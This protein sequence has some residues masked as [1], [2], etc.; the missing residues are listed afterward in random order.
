MAVERLSDMDTCRLCG[1][2]YGNP[3][4]RLSASR[5]YC[6]RCGN[7]PRNIMVVLEMH[8]RQLAEKVRQVEKASADGTRPGD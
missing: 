4:P 1:M 6:V 8:G 5:S 2:P 3:D 7:L